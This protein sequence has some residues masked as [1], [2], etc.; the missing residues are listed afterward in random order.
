MRRLTRSVDRSERGAVL[1]MVAVFSIVMVAMA[2]LVIDVGALLDERRQLQNGADAA[3][4]GVAQL[5]AASCPTGP[6]TA[7]TLRSAAQGLA[8][9]NAKDGKASVDSVTTDFATKRVTVKTSTRQSDDR[10]I[11]PFQFG[12]AVTGSSGKTVHATAVATWAGLQRGKVIPLT[13]SKCEFDA[14]TTKNTVF[15]VPTVIVFHGKAGSCKG[16]PS[17]ADLPGGFGWLMDSNDANSDDCNV[18][19]SAGDIVSE[20]SGV[21]GTP[22]ACDMSTL[23]GK[24]VL[25]SLYDVFTGS[26]TNG[27]YHIYGFGEF[28]LTG[29][30]FASKTGGTVPCK[31][32]D[33]CI[34]GYFIKFVGTGD[35]GGPNVGNQVALVS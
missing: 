31:A 11:L 6:C 27:K 15:N 32:P 33:N 30:R 20:D 16:G 18:T 28:R 21:V 24:D 19:P 14:A 34:G 17:G 8:N 9:G 25:V 7:A 4:L 35:Y 26:G 12:Q 29:F 2:A 1:P 22:H 13:I 5:I 23:L 10:T 3:A